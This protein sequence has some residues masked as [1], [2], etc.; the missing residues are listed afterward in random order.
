MT[1][2]LA[3]AKTNWMTRNGLARLTR[4]WRERAK[5]TEAEHFSSGT[6]IYARPYRA[7]N[8]MPGTMKQNKPTTVAA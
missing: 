3:S 8:Q 2:V 6:M 7:R 1:K 5:A 4:S